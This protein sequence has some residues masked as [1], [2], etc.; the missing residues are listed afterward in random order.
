MP[1]LTVAA[2]RYAFQAEAEKLI[3]ADVIAKLQPQTNSRFLEIGCGPGLL[4]S[5]IEPLVASSVGIDVPS[6]IALAQHQT[7]A[8]LIGARFEEVEI[9]ETFDRILIYGV[10]ST[11]PDFGSVCLFIDKAL[12]LLAP[13][14][15]LL[16]GDIPNSDTKSAFLA[17]ERGSRIQ[18]EW[19]EKVSKTEAPAAK[20]CI[21]H[22]SSKQILSLVAQYRS[23]GL[24][25]YVLPQP[26]DLP[27]GYTR[28]DMLIISP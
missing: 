11:L 9:E 25:C 16:I 15:R 3:A 18:G 6:Q 28:E 26:P 20:E 27:F 7:R 2:G 17:S 14:G 1:N 4:L 8:K 23:R 21:G 22:F 12:S 24:L 10:V 19:T 13:T 5:A